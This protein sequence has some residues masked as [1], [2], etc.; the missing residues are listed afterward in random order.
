VL[1]G[2][3]D[4][5]TNYTGFAIVLFAGV[6]V[7]SLFVLRQREPGA[8]RPFRAIGYPVAPAIFVIACLLIVVNAVYSR[9][10][11]TLAGLAVMAAGIPLYVWLTRRSRVS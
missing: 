10:Q 7:L 4:A 11:P 2:S 8:P 9:P 6:A 3:A 1:S 5:L